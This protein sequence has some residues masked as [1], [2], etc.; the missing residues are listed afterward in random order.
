MARSFSLEMM[1]RT[2]YWRGFTGGLLA[3]VV[4]GAW[5]YFSPRASRKIID[6]QSVNQMESAD[7]LDGSGSGETLG[8]TLPP[9][10]EIMLGKEIR[11]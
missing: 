10:E 9:T 2:E 4:L 5:V 6:S 7:F 1:D 8:C 3:G 11:V